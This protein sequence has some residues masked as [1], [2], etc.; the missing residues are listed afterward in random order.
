MI[1]LLKKMRDNARAVSKIFAERGNK[2]QAEF[3]AGEQSGLQT[4]IYMLTDSGFAKPNKKYLKN[5]EQ[6][7]SGIYSHSLKGRYRRLWQ[8]N[9]RKKTLSILILKF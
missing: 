2:E 6:N 9:I 8:M 3:Y 7:K 4:C 1:E 5:I